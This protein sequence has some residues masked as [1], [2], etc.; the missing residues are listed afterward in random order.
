METIRMPGK[1]ECEMKDFFAFI[2]HLCFLLRAIPV[3][4]PVWCLFMR[5]CGFLCNL[6]PEQSQKLFKVVSICNEG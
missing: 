3:R 5:T 4:T 2:F 6:Q 1:H